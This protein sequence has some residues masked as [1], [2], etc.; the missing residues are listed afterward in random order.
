MILVVYDWKLNRVGSRVKLER[1]TDSS[2]FAERVQLERGLLDRPVLLGQVILHIATARRADV[3]A[4]DAVAQSIQI[5]DAGF[6]GVL[7][8]PGE[9]DIVAFALGHR[10]SGGFEQRGHNGSVFLLVLNTD[11][12]NR[13]ASTCKI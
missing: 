6:A 1:R 10:G 11:S 8:H 4:P 3:A 12:I 9:R 2:R 13:A 5:L 7:S